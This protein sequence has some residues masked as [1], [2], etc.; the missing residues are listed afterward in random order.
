MGKTEST[1][2]VLG[3]NLFANIYNGKRVLVTGHTGFKGSWLSLWLNELGA[4]VTGASLP[5]ENEY[6]HWG[7]I[8]LAIDDRRC[9]IRDSIRVKQIIKNVQPEIVFH[10]A[11]QPLVRRSYK[12]PLETWSTNVMGTVN[13][14]EACRHTPSVRAIV[15]VTTDKCYENYELSRGY[16]ED[17]RLGG[18]DPYS[19]SKAGSELVAASY[20]KAFFDSGSGALL[21]TARAGNVVGGGDWSDDRLIPDLIRAVSEH[22]SLEIRFPN[23]TRPWQHVLESLSGYLLLGQKLLMGCRELAGPW[24][25]GPNSEGN[26]T[27][28]EVLEKLNKAWEDIKWHETRSPQPHETQLLYLNSEK[29]HSK[30]N[31]Q[32]V[33]N[34][35]CSI[36]K[37]ADWYKRWLQSGNVISREQ[38][39][40]YMADASYANIEWANP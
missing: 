40:S 3:I 15:S 11:A 19:A 39:G 1:V 17:D 24:N 29:A 16:R 18:H 28:L 20:R 13:L 14:L 36:E 37:T 2:E 8:N 5:P 31:W 22:K 25:F 27:V 6:N 10:L 34:I 33:W 4:E 23:A 21:A 35:D 38:L 7:L 26:R 30:L 12:D 32:P 9:D